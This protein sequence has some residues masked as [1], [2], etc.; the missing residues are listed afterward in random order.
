M[1]RHTNRFTK[2]RRVFQFE[3][4]EPRAMMT[5][6]PFAMPAL[7]QLMTVPA[8]TA[9]P[10]VVSTFGGPEGPNQIRQAYGF[11]AQGYTGAGQTIAIIVGSIDP[12]LA[13]DVKEFDMEMG[14]ATLNANQLTT[15]NVGAGPA[16]NAAWDLE[17]AL[18]VEYAHTIAPAANIL[19][20]EDDGSLQ[21]QLQGVLYARSVA[22]VSV[23]SMS[24]D[25][26]EFS[27]QDDYEAG[28]FS[29]PSGHTPITFVNSSGDIGAEV[30]FPSALP[31]VLSVGGTT[32]ATVAGTYNYYGEAGWSGSG[33]GV[34]AYETKPSFQNAVQTYGTR[35]T[36]DVAYD[37]NPQTGMDVYNKGHWGVVG[38]TSAGAPQWAGL[39]AL[40]NQGR[41]AV[42]RPTLANAVADMYAM[43][44]SDFNDVA[45]GSNGA[46]AAHTG[47]DLVT[48]L[49]SPVANKLIADLISAEPV[50]QITHVPITPVPIKALGSTFTQP[51]ARALASPQ[52]AFIG[53]TVTATAG[54]FGANHAELATVSSPQEA[55]ANPLRANDLRQPSLMGVAANDASFASANRMAQDHLGLRRLDDAADDLLAALFELK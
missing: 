32:L 24:W 36:P 3:L 37:A 31:N 26:P 35:T 6:T 11:N 45:I 19:V 49:G 10:Q 50:I 48:G 29:T 46:H 33:G 21:D 44:T 4:L 39:I 1:S 22:N 52:V 9:A 23:I 13:A 12:T 41:A 55:Q 5:A 7:P 42:N 28:Y 51:T 2:P 15:K 53:S 25:V 20:V 8:V 47:Y 16:D 14:I 30:T 38:G 27:S 34:S 18:D 43:P 40:A 54:S 17:T